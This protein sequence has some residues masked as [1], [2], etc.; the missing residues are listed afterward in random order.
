MLGEATL[1]ELDHYYEYQL[2]D[3][4]FGSGALSMK[5]VVN[6]FIFSA[7]VEHK[8]KPV[9][10][11][12]IQLFELSEQSNLFSHVYIFTAQMNNVSVSMLQRQF[13]IG[14]NQA[15]WF[16]ELMESLGL[17]VKTD[18]YMRKVVIK[19]VPLLD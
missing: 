1:I 13:I 17:V 3:Q 18:T 10:L 11:P 4:I 7:F 9:S 5:L 19:R 6:R 16:I 8:F 15:V 2:D 12:K 14:Y